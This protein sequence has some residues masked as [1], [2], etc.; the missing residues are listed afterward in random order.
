MIHYVYFILSGEC[1]LIEHMLVEKK[2]Y[3]NK[4]KYKL[5]D[6]QQME[7]NPRQQISRNKN[8]QIFEDDGP[9]ELLGGR[10]MKF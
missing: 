4:V 3:G 10:V 5:Y 8:L 1:R 2:K 6:S 7:K 9:S